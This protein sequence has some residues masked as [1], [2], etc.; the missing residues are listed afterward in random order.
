MMAMSRVA[1]LVSSLTSN[2]IY[3]ATLFMM[4][5]FIFLVGAAVNCLAL[6]VFL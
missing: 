2:K 1:S 6:L 3:A 5:G 4:D